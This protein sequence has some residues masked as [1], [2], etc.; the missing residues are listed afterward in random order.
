MK[1]EF[2]GAAGEVT[3]SCHI[4]TVGS[5]RIL[6]DCGMIQ[7]G[8]KNEQRNRD[9]FP[10]DPKEINAVVLSHAHIDHCGRL[11]LLFKRGFKGSVHTQNA[12]KRLTEILLKDSAWIAQ[13]DAK[14]TNKRLLRGGFPPIEPLYEQDDA[15][16]A[17]K[18]LKGHRYNEIVRVT[19]EIRVRF[20][21]AGHILGSACVEVWLDE[22]GQ[23]RKVLFSGDLGQYNTP[24]LHDPQSVDHADLVLMEST[25]G[26]R[27]HRPRERTIEELGEI[28]K[29]ASG[30]GNILIPAFAVGRSQ[31]ML[32]QFGKHF[33][34]W[35]LK[36]WKI[37]LDSPMAIEASDTYW[38][39]PHLY[40]DEATKLRAEHDEMPKLKNLFFTKSGSESRV[41]NKLERGA[42]II[43]GSGM[44]NAGRIVHHLKHN[45]WRRECQIIMVGYQA[46]GSIGR[47]LVD[48]R[49]FIKIHG[50]SI[51]A[52][53][54][55][56]TVGGLSAHGDEDDLAH[57]YGQ[58][59]H[60][61]PV[62]LV[63]G[64]TRRA[65]LLKKRLENDFPTKV[66]LTEPGDE[67]DLL[68]LQSLTPH[69]D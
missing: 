11:P 47:Q 19:P 28:I 63:H 69:L 4:L 6:L 15:S 58:I 53:A 61:P 26:G 12:S 56:H 60:H 55:V 67:I 44:C 45:L 66:Q 48:G 59:N 27:Q 33:E 52:A 8:R 42:I 7:G 16:H 54:Q 31:E 65:D 20:R 17:I 50:Q 1:L 40:D 39:Y 30:K 35:G 18:N 13:M 23:Q 41:I 25:Y 38:D 29:K 24:I 14:Q 22:E 51:R 37:F 3:G 57:W 9:P 62:R 64:E 10:F 2:F 21:D 46:Q 36:D 5:S 32:Y 68:S 49:R 34:E 43:A